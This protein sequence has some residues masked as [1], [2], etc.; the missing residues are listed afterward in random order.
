[1]VM[2]FMSQM[3]NNYGHMKVP[4]FECQNWC[5]FLVPKLAVKSMDIFCQNGG[6]IKAK[7]VQQIS[8]KTGGNIGTKMVWIF[9]LKLL[10]IFVPDQM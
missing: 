6:Q 3:F 2:M 1:M 5:A 10:G 8:A 9:V 7:M 4:K